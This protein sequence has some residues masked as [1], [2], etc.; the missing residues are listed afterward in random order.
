M[1]GTAVLRPHEELGAGSW[2]ADLEAL[3]GELRALPANADLQ[4]R[5]EA[6]QRA[7]ALLAVGFAAELEWLARCCEL[8]A[9]LNE[10]L[11]AA[12][13]ALDQQVVA[14]RRVRL[15]ALADRNGQSR[16]LR[17]SVPGPVVPDEPEPPE[18]ALEPPVAHPPN[19]G[20]QSPGKRLRPLAERLRPP[21]PEAVAAWRERQERIKA[22]ASK[23]GPMATAPARAPEPA[24]VPEVEAEAQP[25]VEQRPEP[26]PPRRRQAGRIPD[27]FMPTAEAMELL[28]ISAQ[29]IGRWRKL[30]RF[31]PEGEGWVWVTAGKVAYAVA[32]IER[33]EAELQGEAGERI[34][35]LLDLNPCA[36]ADPR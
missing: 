29:T 9:S 21:D 2:E 4:A 28:D 17:V 11:I 26:A 7:V 34:D 12:P 30:G 35:T 25:A 16:P 24:A 3:A 20:T 32:A 22:Q 13:A 33:M 31:G 6:S 5:L 10:P 19:G 1:T 36:A 18:A 15:A 23:R 27:G 14:V 8:S